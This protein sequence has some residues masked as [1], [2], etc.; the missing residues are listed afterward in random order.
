MG[1]GVVNVKLRMFSVLPFPVET[2]SLGHWFLTRGDFASQGTFEKKTFWDVT[3]VGEVPGLGVGG[4]GMG[5]RNLVAS[6]A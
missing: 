6:G 3:T 5:G 4:G 2:H 1:K